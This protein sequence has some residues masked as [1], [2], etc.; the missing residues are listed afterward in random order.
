MADLKKFLDKQGVS[1][2]WSKI[3]EK[4]AADVAAEAT[5]R[6][7]AI[8]AAIADEVV[9][10]NETISAVIADEVTRVDLVIADVASDVA[11]L[12]AKVGVIPADRTET[13]LVDFINKKAEETLAAAS[14]NSTETAASVKAQLDQYKKDNDAAVALK[15]NQA[16]LEALDARVEA[17]EDAIEVLNGTADVEGSVDAKIAAA[18]AA[19]ME[20]PDETLNSIKELVKW[21]QDHAAD[22]LEMSNNVSANANAI[23]A[24][25][26]LVGEE[27]VADQIAD[28]IADALNL[29]GEAKYALATELAAAIERIADIEAD[30]LKA[31][32]KTELTE[33]IALKADATALAEVKATADAA[34]VKTEVDA[35]FAT[36]NAAVALK[37]AQTDLEAEAALA[38]AAEK[39]NADAIAAI[40]ALTDAEI[41]EAIAA[42]AQ[43]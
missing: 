7:E 35:A 37:A 10:R 19:I 17:N 38:R 8:A 26:G 14:G 30:Y 25:Q 42:V 18:V 1:T 41:E 5:A 36:T 40:V 23:T 33:A 13:N 4:V 20:N 21:T 22:A 16:D 6:D 34:A 32:D 39:A 11:D 43:A 15:A 24:L 3:A 31:A 27:N 29:E 12:D 9:A 2:L 28:A